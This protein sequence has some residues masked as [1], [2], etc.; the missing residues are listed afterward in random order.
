VILHYLFVVIKKAVVFER[1][2]FSLTFL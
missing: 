1:L 2:P